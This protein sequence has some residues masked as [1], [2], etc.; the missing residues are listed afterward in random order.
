[1]AQARKS[2]EPF[3]E[4]PA[5]ASVLRRLSNTSNGT[6]GSFLAPRMTSEVFT[7]STFGAVNNSPVKND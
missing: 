5:Q 2:P 4:K 6:P 1:M 7:L 3:G